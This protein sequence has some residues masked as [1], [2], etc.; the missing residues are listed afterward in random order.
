M[1]TPLWLPSSNCCDVP[2]AVEDVLA[3]V[4]AAGSKTGTQPLSLAINASV[5]AL[6]GKAIPVVDV[7]VALKAVFTFFKK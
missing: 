4:R 1:V 2:C 3:V 5:V 7:L 6:E